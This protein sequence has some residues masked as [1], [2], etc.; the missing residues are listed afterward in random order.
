MYIL[1]L[2]LKKLLDWTTVGKFAKR[3]KLQNV[4][5]I[6]LGE[7]RGLLPNLAVAEA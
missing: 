6:A 2:A 4:S 5:T 7:G 1:H 3:A